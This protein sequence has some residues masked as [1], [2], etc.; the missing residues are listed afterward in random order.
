MLLEQ[1]DVKIMEL[2]ELLGQARKKADENGSVMLEVKKTDG[3]NAKVGDFEVNM[4]KKKSAIQTS[5]GQPR[6]G[7]R[8]PVVVKAADLPLVPKAPFAGVL[9]ATSMF[10]SLRSS[11]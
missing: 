3:D 1:K 10:S 5:T 11:S 8:S 9:W 4:T 6:D 7:P 2:E